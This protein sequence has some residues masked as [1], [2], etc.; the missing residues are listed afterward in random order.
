MDSDRNEDNDEGRTQGGYEK[1]PRGIREGRESKATL[2]AAFSRLTS[3]TFTNE[4]TAW[5]QVTTTSPFVGTETY[6]YSVRIFSPTGTEVTL[7]GF[8]A[9]YTNLGNVPG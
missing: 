6:S 1:G 8:L 5:P 3:Y 7:P 9:S 2:T 4:Y